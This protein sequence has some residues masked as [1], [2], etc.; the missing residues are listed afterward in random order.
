MPYAEPLT[1]SEIEERLAQLDD[2]THS[3]NAITKTYKI[4][5]AAGAAFIAHVVVVE[6]AMNHHADILYRYGGVQFTITTHAADH[7]L[8]HKDFDLA[9]EIA[10]VAQAHGAVGGE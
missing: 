1:D 3:G 4:R 8:T 2:W 5:Y 6:E 7:R 10:R 9:K